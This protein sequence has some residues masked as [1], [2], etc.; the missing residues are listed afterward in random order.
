MLPF[1]PLS[2]LL[3]LFLFC[4]GVTA[5][6]QVPVTTLADE[7]D[8]GAGGSGVSLREAVALAEPD[9]N[10]YFF[11]TL[12]LGG[13]QT[14][15]LTLGDIIISQ[16]VTITGPGASTL[17]ISGGNTQRIFQVIDGGMSIS[18]VTLA[19]GR[20]KGGNG[21]NGAGGGGGGMGAGGA[22]YLYDGF[23]TATNVT[24]LNNSAVG[25]NGGN[26]ASDS[27]AAGG[28]G[29]SVGDGVNADGG[30][31]TFVNI[32]D[33]NGGVGGPS[34]TGAAGAGGAPQQ[35]GGAGGPG[36]GGGGAGSVR[37]NPLGANPGGAGGFGGGGG[38]SGA[39]W[40]ATDVH[41]GGAGGFGGG[42]GGAGVIVLPDART[43]PGGLGGLF[44]G[45][46][47]STTTQTAAGGGGGAGLGGAVFVNETAVFV[48]SN[49][50]FQ[51]NTATGGAAGGSFGAGPAPTA[52][53]GK[54]GA[55]FVQIGGVAQ[56]TNATYSGNSA[57]D[58]GSRA[59]DN[60]DR[61]GTVKVAN[62]EINDLS[63]A[64]D[65]NI[66][67]G[68][69][70]TAGG[71]ITLR[72]V[73]QEWRALG[74][75][76][77]ISFASSLFESGPQTIEMDSALEEYLVETTLTIVGPGSDL[78]TVDG[79]DIRRIFQV[80]AG[81]L[82]IS[83]VTLAN[84]YGKGGDGGDGCG[85]AGGGMG[86][87]G[88][89]YIYDGDVT[90]TEVVFLDNRAEGG[91]GGD[92]ELELLSGGGGG[93]VG[94]GLNANGQPGA[95]PLGSNGG[96]GGPSVLSPGG[97]GGV[98]PFPNPG[99]PGGVGAGGGGGASSDFGFGSGGAG[100][101]GG[102]GGGTGISR[103]AATAS[104]NG[105]AGGFGGGGGGSGLH[106]LDFPG[107]GG[108]GGTFAGNGGSTPSAN[109]DNGGG[110]GGAGLGGAV[111]VNDT[112]TFACT[113]CTFSNNSAAGGNAG[114]NRGG[115]ATPGAGQGKGGAVF[116]RTG[117]TATLTNVRFT[118]SAATD[119]GTT[120]TDNRSLW[121]VVNWGG[122]G[123]AFEVNSLGDEG[124]ASPGDLTAETTG[125]VTTLRA[126]LEELDALGLAGTVTFD[127]ALFS[128]GP[129][130]IVLAN[131]TLSA[132]SSGL[133]IQGPGEELLTMDGSGQAASV[134]SFG[135]GDLSS[136]SGMTIIGGQSVPL[137]AGIVVSR[138]MNMENVAIRDGT[139]LGSGGGIY[140]AS[141]LPLTLRNCTVADCYAL[142]FGGG[143]W[144]ANPATLVVAGGCTIS[145][146]E[147][148]QGG[149]GMAVADGAQLFMFNSTL[150]GNSADETGGGARLSNGSGLTLNF[151]TLTN[152]TGDANDNG[153]GAAGGIVADGTSVMRLSNSIVAGNL[154]NPVG[155]ASPPFASPD[156][157]GTIISDGRNLFGQES[158][159]GSVGTDFFLANDF[160]NIEDVLEPLADN[161]GPTQTHALTAESPAIDR[162]NN[163]QA[164]EPLSG[165]P[166]STDQRGAGFERI[167]GQRA[168]IGAFEATPEE[169]APSINIQRAAGQ[170]TTANALPILF[171][172]TTSERVYG[173]EIGDITFATGANITTATLTQTGR[174][175]Y[176]LSVDAIDVDG[177]VEPSIA[178][179][180]ATDVFGNL[181]TV[182]PPV[183][184]GVV[185][186]T[187]IPTVEITG[188]PVAPFNT[189]SI[190]LSVAFS[191]PVFGFNA[192]ALVLDNATAEIVV[193]TDGDSTYTVRV[194]PIVQGAVSVDLP[195][196]AA[197]DGAGNVST[198]LTAPIQLAYD[199]VAPGVALS[200]TAGSPTDAVPVPFTVTF[201][202]PITGFTVGDLV[203]TNG[204]A[205]NFAGAGANYT[206]DVF[207]TK[208]GTVQV[209]LP[210]GA[211]EDAAG[212]SSL[213]ADTV[214][215][216]FD[217]VPPSVE[218]I[219]RESPTALTNASAVDFRVVFSE[220]VT[221]LD[222]AD[223]VVDT[224]ATLTGP[225][226]AAVVGLG[227]EF[228]VTVDTGAGEG[229]LS[230]DLVV[231][232]TVIDAANR[233]LNA[234][235]SSGEAYQV[236]RNAPTATLFSSAADPTTETSIPVSVNFSESVSGFAAEDIVAV[237]ATVENFTG[238]GAAYSFN[239]VPAAGGLVS[240]QVPNG[241][242]LDPA[243]N[244]NIASTVL[245]R[246]YFDLAACDTAF[247]TT[248]INQNN[249]VSLSELLRVI[250]FYNSENF[251]CATGTE[252]GYAPGIGDHNCCPHDSD[253]NPQNWVISLSELLRL[254]QFYNSLGYTYCPADNTEDGFCPGL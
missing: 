102:G 77:T 92:G 167:L 53:E 9:G 194:T 189:S 244:E 46:G 175:L 97:A 181:S 217:T 226:V 253:Y 208:D 21:G 71:T 180:A 94:D 163:L 143:L 36:A 23:V 213:E 201:T 100:G 214:V 10:V 148:G 110:G 60:D 24:F 121:G 223:F 234:P 52:G 127:P 91:D 28:G 17:T 103:L 195:A 66:G 157:A 240:A 199:S 115:G 48:A 220:P 39:T 224:S 108:T 192:G 146:N 149:G 225:F 153:G 238:G 151:C 8:G 188:A 55:L 27:G 101:F 246:T 79:G 227:D 137:G 207:A 245:S 177:L 126:A 197:Q 152:N 138:E 50:T 19:N 141:G 205:A 154:G 124:D 109:N 58:A 169:D 187:A 45:D 161:G 144:V 160:A 165:T 190:D 147:S 128:G 5:S 86:A 106:I 222:T 243:G 32:Q 22:I 249:V 242:A 184:L 193:G 64:P 47:G 232:G 139:T 104:C 172:V 215:F 247:H 145:G 178:D 1:R 70:A 204:N 68:A 2:Y 54:G 105:G 133:E 95:E 85:G 235:F 84:G 171:D 134:F 96:T 136:L 18:D 31:S 41:P 183:D 198:A 173:L 209:S 233:A 131:G 87:G 15:T 236:D 112:A 57:N 176:V 210:A 150:S 211:A 123:T 13:P 250:Q 72:A 111:F 25:G 254:I 116:V 74:G 3:A 107:F 216:V 20:A 229:L 73:L 11:P 30:N 129:A 159:S 174:A 200:N 203:V 221:G 114:A 113:D 37:N 219:V 93:G 90:A 156:V 4:M 33:A 168:D 14:L 230:I 135:A 241:A 130:S 231:D 125:G 162:G 179:G 196:G 75:G 202:E 76:G 26:G 12:F 59:I 51:G 6:A 34:A 63:D 81:G 251:R 191:E 98:V 239:L 88:A 248:D 164:T 67:N 40:L 120:P 29:G 228:L 61:W 237:N 82:N 56:L 182:S 83:G 166:I 117:G 170:G 155:S 185:Y 42:G 16:P 35:P 158:V 212:N 218:T 206:F 80:L 142:S 122:S 252:D 132:G 118:G 44:A 140:V 69:V 43:A 99:E 89:I 38:G 78:L 62:V 65:A 49:C 186:D 119:A 7:N